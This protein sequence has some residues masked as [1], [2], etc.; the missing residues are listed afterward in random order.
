MFVITTP[1]DRFSQY[2]IPV[3]HNK[4]LSLWPLPTLTSAITGRRTADTIEATDSC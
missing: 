2:P 1:D 3:M 4:R